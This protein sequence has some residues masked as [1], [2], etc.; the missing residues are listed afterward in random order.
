VRDL[1]YY[2]RIAYLELKRVFIVTG[3]FFVWLCAWV[4]CFAQRKRA[5]LIAWLWAGELERRGCTTQDIVES[6][7]VASRSRGDS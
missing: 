2:R 6:L 3:Y 4:D 7:R 5:R 1:K